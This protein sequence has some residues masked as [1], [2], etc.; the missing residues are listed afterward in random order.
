VLALAASA[1]PDKA[2][3]FDPSELYLVGW[4]HMSGAPA[5]RRFDWIDGELHETRLD[6]G[7]VA[8]WRSDW[9]E[10]LF[11]LSTP[12][13][14]RDLLAAQRRR[15]SELELEPIGHTLHVFEVTKHGVSFTRRDG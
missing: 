12:C 1:M 5:A 9:P 10:P 4:S 8:P 14:Q 13:G 6:A 2:P 11:D 15:C 7:S 3:Q